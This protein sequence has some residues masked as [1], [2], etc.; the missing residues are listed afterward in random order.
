MGERGRE[1][2]SN[3]RSRSVSLRDVVRKFIS[4]Q[5][6]AIRKRPS[7]TK[8][9]LN[10]YDE[11]LCD[12]YPPPDN[13]IQ[14]SCYPCGDAGVVLS[15]QEQLGLEENRVGGINPLNTTTP[16][17][18]TLPSS[19]AQ[20]ATNKMPCSQILGHATCQSGRHFFV[21]P[22]LRP[23]WPLEYPPGFGSKSGE[24][25]YMHIQTCAPDMVFS[26]SIR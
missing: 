1:T 24:G 20:C 9:L 17:F 25:P 23:R 22:Y 5:T 21:S 14:P 8:G 11:T 3:R 19:D 26:L 15:D 12:S 6:S 10:G 13:A 7:N 16:G 4:H 18:G 2:S